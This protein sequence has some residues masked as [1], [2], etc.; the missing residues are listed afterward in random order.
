M[1]LTISGQ[2]YM[3]ISCPEG[4]TAKPM[5]WHTL[6]PG[7]WAELVGHDTPGVEY[8]DGDTL[9]IDGAE[10]IITTHSRSWMVP[11]LNRVV[12]VTPRA[13]LPVSVHRVKVWPSTVFTEVE[14]TT[15]LEAAKVAL[16]G[17][18]TGEHTVTFK[19]GERAYRVF[20][21]NTQMLTYRGEYLAD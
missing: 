3:L 7:P 1:N 2:H 11:D 18:D 20:A 16:R 21:G 9:V 6:R 8:S 12:P 10:Y 19:V 17:H 4:S 14:A 5:G 13:P 15:S